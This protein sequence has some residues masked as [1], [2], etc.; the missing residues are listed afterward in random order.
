MYQVFR[1]EG[2]SRPSLKNARVKN[3]GQFLSEM[4]DMDL[5]N[6]SMPGASNYFIGKQVE[7]AIEQRPDLIVF[8]ITTPLRFEYA[9]PDDNAGVRPTL[10]DFNFSTYTNPD[11]E[12]F[13][14]KIRSGVYKTFINGWVREVD[15][16]EITLCLTKYLGNTGLNI[17]KE[18]FQIMGTFAI[19]E[20]SKIPYVCVD[21]GGRIFTPEELSDYNALSYVP[22]FLL[23]TYPL[24]GDFIHYNEDGHK[25]IAE[26]I[27]QLIEQKQLL[28]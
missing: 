9:A 11:T 1:P 22:R 7:W 15:Q 5:V 21:Y 18:R 13:K 28:K 2:S 19:L 24:E 8:A 23:D 20:K 4:L 27:K 14:G 6:L 25:H 3:Y 17:D 12:Q 10:H 16:E 26:Q